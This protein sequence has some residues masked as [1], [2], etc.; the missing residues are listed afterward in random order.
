M[1]IIA[2][3]VAAVTA[4]ATSIAYMRNL[5]AGSQEHPIPLFFG[6][7]ACVPL[8]IVLVCLPAWFASALLLGLALP[9]WAALTAYCAAAVLPWEVVRRRHNRRVRNGIA[10]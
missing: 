4:A 10:L 9:S 8:W 7:R 5:I 2:A 6:R 3:I 1:Q